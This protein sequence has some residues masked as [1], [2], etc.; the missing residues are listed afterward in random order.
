[1]PSYLRAVVLGG[2]QRLALRQQEIA[3]EPVLDADDFTHLAELGD[4]FEQNDFHFGLSV[5]CWVRGI[6]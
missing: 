3:R 5:V 6:D 2:A 1:M 4:A